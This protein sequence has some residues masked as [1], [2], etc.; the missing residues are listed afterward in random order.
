MRLHTAALTALV[1]TLGAATTARAQQASRAP[2]KDAP[3]RTIV[4][5][6]VLPTPQV[7]TVRPRDV[8]SYDRAVLSPA[9]FDHHFRHTLD[10][11]KVVT[12]R[13]A[14]TLAKAPGTDPR[15]RPRAPIAA[16]PQ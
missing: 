9:F 15:L 4:I 13:E 7:V 1:L 2:G 14:L 5:R 12:T 11:P 3:R 16:Q 10:A 8:P 6:G